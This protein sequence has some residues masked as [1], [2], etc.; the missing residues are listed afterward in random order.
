MYFFLCVPGIGEKPFAIFSSQERSIIV[1]VV[2]EFTAY[3]AELQP[4]AE[5]LLR[6]PYGRSF[7]R[8]EDCTL[9]FVGGGTGSASLLEI[10]H[11]CRNRGRQ[12]FVLGARSRDEFFD[13]E[14][15]RQLGAVSLATDDGTLGFHGYVSDLLRELVAEIPALER[16]KLVF[17]NC[18]PEPMVWESFS[19]EKAIVPEDRIFGSIEYLTSCGVGIC[20]KCAS[21]SGA[22]SCI[23]GPFLALRDFQP[24]GRPCTSS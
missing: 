5:I 16:E 18:G 17:I 20:G 4:G 7:P 11:R 23:D 19:I 10:A 24:R 15:F 9:V 6:G 8:L 13:L 21:P 1:R 12:I 2:G 14:R 22:L 3:L